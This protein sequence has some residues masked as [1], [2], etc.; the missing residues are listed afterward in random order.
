[1]N[2]NVK[3]FLRWTPEYEGGRKT[4]F[5]PGMR[6]CPVIA[7]EGIPSDHT[8][9]SVSVINDSVDGRKA[10]ATMSFLSPEAPHELLR[11]GLVFDLYDGP[12]IVANGTVQ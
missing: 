3:V 12:K 6:Y 5:P 11:S 8:L 10:I 2:K 4:I 1:M 7:S 9:W